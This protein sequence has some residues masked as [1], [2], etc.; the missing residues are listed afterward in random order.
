MELI[1]QII[2]RE[3]SINI[4]N[5]GDYNFVGTINEFVLKDGH[6]AVNILFKNKYSKIQFFFAEYG[7]ISE[8]C[9]R[10]QAE[11][12]NDRYIL[13]HLDKFSEIKYGKESLRMF[14]LNAYTGDKEECVKAAAAFFFKLLSHP[15]L[16]PIYIGQ[17]VEINDYLKS[18]WEHTGK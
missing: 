11:L 4:K 15:E 2:Y 18:V 6:K 12:Y 8:L 5:L 13:V 17:F 7:A 9:S 10:F 1:H 14:S 16:Q 3:L